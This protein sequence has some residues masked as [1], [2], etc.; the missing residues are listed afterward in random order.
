MGEVRSIG[1][2]KV[3]KADDN[4][5]WTPAECLADTMED[6]RSGAVKCDKLLIICLDTSDNQ[7]RIHRSAC[8]MKSSEQVSLLEVAKTRALKDMGYIP[9][10]L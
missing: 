2:L 10:G 4:S 3:T 6:I 9:D 7:Y 5:L 8:D 1:A